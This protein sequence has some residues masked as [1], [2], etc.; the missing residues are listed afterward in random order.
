MADDD[1][2]NVHVILIWVGDICVFWWITFF[3]T[4]K[5]SAKEKFRFFLPKAYFRGVRTFV[6]TYKIT[7]I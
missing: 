5:L 2:S 1:D 4:N 7:T 3:G 6:R